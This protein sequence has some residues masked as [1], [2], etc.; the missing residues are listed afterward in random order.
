MSCA[1]L[2]HYNAL[3]KKVITANDVNRIHIAF[4]N[5]VTPAEAV[6]LKES[7]FV[8]GV[9]LLP[10]FRPEIKVTPDYIKAEGRLWIDQLFDGLHVIGKPDPEPFR[11]HDLRKSVTLFTD[12]GDRAGKSLLITLPGSNDRLMMPIPA[13]LQNLNASATDVLFI[14]D[15]TRS[16]YTAGL[17][18][19]PHR[20]QHLARG[21]GN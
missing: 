6:E 12:G 18:G 14:R 9:H 20:L 3:L 15:G 19:W 11:R 16:D 17:E 21:S 7:L 13:F 10:E 1:M 8:P 2:E 4:G 5:T